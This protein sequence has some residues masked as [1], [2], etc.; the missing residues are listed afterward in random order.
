MRVG[1]LAC[2]TYDNNSDEVLGQFTQAAAHAAAYFAER[3][4]GPSTPRT[5]RGAVNLNALPFRGPI[6]Q[7]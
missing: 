1:H 2:D 7:R 5:P 6:P 3:A 4:H